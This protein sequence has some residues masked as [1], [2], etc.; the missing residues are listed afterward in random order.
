MSDFLDYLNANCK[1]LSSEEFKEFL[2]DEEYIEDNYLKTCY[3]CEND[4]FDMFKSAVDVYDYL[5]E[6]SFKYSRD[7]NNNKKNIHLYGLLCNW[8]HSK[9]IPIFANAKEH[10]N[11]SVLV[12]N[13]CGKIVGVKLNE[14]LD[15]EY[16]YL[17]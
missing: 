16:P 2:I 11:L 6:L 13:H 4:S 9:G 10:P 15:W 7:I 12:C 5:N 14:G 8:F 3:Y 1:N 17:N